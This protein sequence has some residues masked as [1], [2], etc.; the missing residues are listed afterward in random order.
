MYKVF[1]NQK[2]ILLTTEC[3]EVSDDYPLFFAKYTTVESLL[4]AL[5]SKRV[6]GLY[7]Y[8]PNRE[9]LEKH[10]LKFF[11]KVEAAGGFVAHQDGRFLFIYRNDKWDLPKGK[12]QKKEVLYEGAIREVIEETGVA[13]LIISMALPTTYH[14]YKAN[15]R[16]KLKLTHWFLM[17]TNYGGPLIPQIEENIQKVKWVAK[18]DIPALFDNVYENIKIVVNEVISKS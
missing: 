11:P 13:D 3:N 14:L 16:F 1:Y 5:K 10:F 9:K 7:F 18:D 17:K 4:K 12:I 15:G 2:P 8:H 6:S